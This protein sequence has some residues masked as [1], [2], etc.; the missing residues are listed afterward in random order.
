MSNW[1]PRDWDYTYEDVPEK[2]PFFDPHSLCDPTIFEAGADAMLKAISSEIEKVENPF[3][4]EV[5]PLMELALRGECQ[6]S[7]EV[8]RQKILSLLKGE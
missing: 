7:F 4:A 5:F 1:R 2:L 6:S 8:A 3:N